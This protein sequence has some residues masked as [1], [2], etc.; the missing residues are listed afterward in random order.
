MHKI[1]TTQL[2]LLLATALLPACLM[3]EEAQK[4]IG[5]TTE[6]CPSYSLVCQ[7]GF[8]GK[9][10]VTIAETSEKEM[11]RLAATPEMQALIDNAPNQ[12]KLAE[13]NNPQ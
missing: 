3:A 5:T 12:P 1:L 6:S 7:A 13:V 9:R 2:S 4:S 10:P 8:T 11:Q